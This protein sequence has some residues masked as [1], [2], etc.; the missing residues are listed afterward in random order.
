MVGLK[1]RPPAEKVI[2]T[3]ETLAVLPSVE[4][5]FSWEMTRLSVALMSTA[6]VSEMLTDWVWVKVS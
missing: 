2:L 3:L 6:S 5:T 1:A 4:T